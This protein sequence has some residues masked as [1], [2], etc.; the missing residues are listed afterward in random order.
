MK[1]LKDQQQ[2][3]GKTTPIG[4][5]CQEALDILKE[6]NNILSKHLYAGIATV[7]DPCFNYTVFTKLY[8]IG[9]DLTDMEREASTIQCTQVKK[10]FK[11]CFWHMR[12]ESKQ[13]QQLVASENW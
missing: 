10:E 4:L 1:K 11:D 12:L 3:W 9:H 2:I 5:A 8:P 7:L 13:W 6:Y